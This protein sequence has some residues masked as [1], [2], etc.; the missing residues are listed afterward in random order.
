MIEV[1]LLCVSLSAS[2]SEDN[3]SDLL[4]K[5]QRIRENDDGR[6]VQD[7]DNAQEEPPTEGTGEEKDED[8]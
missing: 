3:P 6:H 1:L 4:E 7:P 8:E 2:P 5:L